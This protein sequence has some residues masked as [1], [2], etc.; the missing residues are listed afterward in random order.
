MFPP[1]WYFASVPAD[2]TVTA[3]GLRS[4]GVTVHVLDGNARLGAF[5][6]PAAVHALQ[7][8]STYGDDLAHAEATAL[9]TSACRQAG[10]RSGATCTPR[11]LGFGDTVESHLPTALSVGCDASLNPALP[12]LDELVD[13]TVGFEP[14]VVGVALVHPEQRVQAVAFA[15]RLRTRGFDG[16]LV[17]YGSLEDALSP[18]DLAP[19]LLGLPR[20][21]LFDLYDGVV[22]GSAVD[23]IFT[24]ACG[25][26]APGVLAG[27]QA[28]LPQPQ[29]Q[30]A[31]A[32][33]DFGGITASS[34][35]FPAPVVD[36]RLSHGCPWA[37]CAFCAIHTHQPDYVQ[38]VPGAAAEA[39][40]LAHESLGTTFFR[41]RDCLLTPRGIEQVAGEVHGLSFRAHWSC[42]ARFSRDLDR[43][44]MERGRDAGLDE[45]W[46]GLESYS[47]R[48]R[49]HMGK[50]IPQAV[51]ARVLA[52]AEASGVR[53]RLLCIL[54]FPGEHPDETMET[55][56]FLRANRK[57]TDG[58]SL[59]PFE[60]MRHSPVAAA[61][62]TYDV[63]LLE[64]DLPR[65]ERLRA[66]LPFR[67]PDE[68]SRQAAITNAMH[69]ARKL[70]TSRDL[71]LGPD[72]SHTWMHEVGP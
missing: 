13:Q 38:P 3:G 70:F 24:L 18:L 40:G 16:K 20:H 58:V 41:I 54:G 50:G 15:A 10:E 2:L 48:V 7:R 5:L 42:R 57:R 68:E 11:V 46:L 32:V 51:I 62:K 44:V 53:V 26:Q 23:S 65:H 1:G 45:I 72:P 52:D 30:P 8:P 21:A 36:L 49:D 31:P 34:Y 28:N 17:L 25:R 69:E 35:P 19:D 56:A 14:E 59:T 9:W 47:L 60:L 55:I 71:L 61:P 29:P 64:D 33:P 4:R 67:T 27:G 6:A 66:S 63:T 37:R 22:L 12:V 39:M 43:D